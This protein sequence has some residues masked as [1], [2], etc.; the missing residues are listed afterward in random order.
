MDFLYLQC[1]IWNQDQGIREIL[2]GLLKH[3]HVYYFH[4]TLPDILFETL[5]YITMV[6]VIL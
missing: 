3:M 1:F 6:L 4:Y 2:F 5:F